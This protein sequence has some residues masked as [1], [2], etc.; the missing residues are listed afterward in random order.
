SIAGPN[1][2][3]AVEDLNAMSDAAGSVDR[4]FKIV[5]ST[6]ANQ[7]DIFFSRIK[8]STIGIGNTLLEMSGGI[9]EF[10]NNAISDAN[11]LSAALDQEV[12]KVNE[13]F[14]EYVNA[15]TAAERR[16]EILED[17]KQINPAIVSGINNEADAYLLLTDRVKNYNK[18]IAFRKAFEDDYNNIASLQ[19]DAA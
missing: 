12:E 18:E 17:L 15:N 9:A 3:G 8:S 11:D 16:S 5:T 13:L 2:E 1:F 10:L 4:S 6:A 14:N 19:E 7:W